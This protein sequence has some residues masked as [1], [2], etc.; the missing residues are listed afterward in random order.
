[1]VGSGL[2]ES[3]S[4]MALGHR[5][6]GPKSTSIFMDFMR[7]QRFPSMNG[8][9]TFSALCEDVSGTLARNNCY[10]NNTSIAHRI[11]NPPRRTSER[12]V[13]NVSWS[14]KIIGSFSHNYIAA[15]DFT[16]T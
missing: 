14:S 11:E 3:T 16:A 1:M 9:R 15:S 6:V 5:R 4:E 7:C 10:E 12:F 13:K 2:A 8:N